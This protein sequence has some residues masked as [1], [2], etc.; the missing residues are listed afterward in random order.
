MDL[1]YDQI[2][3]EAYAADRAATPTQDTQPQGTT[4]APKQPSLNTELQ[5]TFQAFS[6]SPWAAKLGGLWGNVR[7]QAE[8]VRKNTESYYEEAKREVDDLAVDTAKWGAGLKESL[9][10][11]TRALSTDEKP[12]EESK[13]GEMLNEAAA[14]KERRESAARLEENDNFIARFRSEA[15]KRLKDIEKAEDAADEALLRFG[16]N[17]RN[18]LREAVA[19]APPEDEKKGGEILFESKDLAGKRV[20]HTTRLDAQLH[21]IHTTPD[22]FTKDL[23]SEQWATFKDKFEVDAETQRIA[24]DLEKYPELRKAMEGLVPEKV[25]Y[26]DFWCRYYFLRHV[27]ETE[28]QRRREMLKGKKCLHATLEPPS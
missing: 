24:E 4:T 27:L 17:I 2:N 7:K 3:Q 5:E 12:R 8:D 10:S 9:V 16:T 20:L 28:E 21:V 6:N 19:V 23:D 18:F 13:I 1:A 22:K 14:E 25:E 11:R 26:K 15:A